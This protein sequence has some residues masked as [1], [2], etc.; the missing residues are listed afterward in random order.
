M[1]R[2]WAQVRPRCCDGAFRG[3]TPEDQ[4]TCLHPSGAWFPTRRSSTL[5]LCLFIGAVVEFVATEPEPKPA[6]RRRCGARNRAARAS[7]HRFNAVGQRT[8]ATDIESTRNY[9]WQTARS[10]RTSS[11]SGPNIV[12]IRPFALSLACPEPVEGSKEPVLS[13]SKGVAGLRQAQG[14]RKM[15]YVNSIG[16]GPALTPNAL[17]SD[18]IRLHRSGSPT[19]ECLFGDHVVPLFDD[20]AIRLLGIAL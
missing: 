19:Y 18:P 12:H 13:L 9:R 15:D 3:S 20:A 2:A 10:N 7:L 17:P 11:G 16:S 1:S 6:R 5:S 4:Q 8:D 14:E